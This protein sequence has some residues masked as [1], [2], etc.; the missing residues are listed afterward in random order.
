M[1]EQPQKE[2]ILF[3]IKEIESN[4]KI[5]QRAIS[6]NLGISLGKT[7]YLLRELIKKGLIEVKNFSNHPGKL[8]KINY[9]LTKQGLQH[10]LQLMQHFLKIKE[11]EYNLIKRELEE[12]AAREEAKI[13]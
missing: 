6:Q 10:K 3:I 7:N 9:I 13:A 1:I 12:L 5:T 11:S 2:D 4:P 8:R